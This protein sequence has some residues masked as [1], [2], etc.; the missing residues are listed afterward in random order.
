MIKSPLFRIIPIIFL[1]RLT[2]ILYYTFKFNN[3]ILFVDAD[4][5]YNYLPINNGIMFN[6]SSTNLYKTAKF[7]KVSTIFYLNIRK[8]DFFLKKLFNL[9]CINI[10]PNNDLNKSNVDLYLKTPNSKITNYL[11]YIFTMGLYLKIKN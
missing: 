1:K 4:I 5:N 11:V 10:C 9:N 8:K 6:R 7:F 2:S 3:N